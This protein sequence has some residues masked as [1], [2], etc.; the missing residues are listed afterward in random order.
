MDPMSHSCH[1]NPTA[2][3]ARRRICFNGGFWWL[4]DPALGYDIRLN[5]EFSQCDWR[6]DRL[7]DCL[8][9]G[10]R[11]FSRMVEEGIGTTAKHWLQEITIVAARHLLREEHKIEAVAKK[12]GFR[13]VFDF[14]KEFKKIMGVSPSRFRNSERLRSPLP[15][16]KN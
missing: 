2:G 11:T 3:L 7:C 1:R 13:H 10:K 9:I 4:I 6:I 5:G 15:E 12:L 8:G 16:R 14:D